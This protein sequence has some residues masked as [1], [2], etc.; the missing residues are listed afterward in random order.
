MDIERADVDIH[1]A[2]VD[3]HEANLMWILI[4][5]RGIPSFLVPCLLIAIYIV[6]VLYGCKSPLRSLP[7]TSFICVISFSGSG[8]LH[9]HFETE[10]IT[11]TPEGYSSCQLGKYSK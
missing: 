5:I 3:I 4:R 11:F 8:F 1:R 10:I 6:K 7:S 9:F 2:N